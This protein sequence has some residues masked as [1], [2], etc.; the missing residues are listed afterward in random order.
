M[1]NRRHDSVSTHHYMSSVPHRVKPEPPAQLLRLLSRQVAGIRSVA[2]A[3]V[4]LV[5]AAVLDAEV[6][7][8]AVALGWLAAMLLT[9]YIVSCI[10]WKLDLPHI[11]QIPI[12][13]IM[14]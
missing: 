9:L 2:G 11:P 6:H 3:V 7:R 12:P 14:V 10:A 1:N 4:F 13:V 8:R 5:G